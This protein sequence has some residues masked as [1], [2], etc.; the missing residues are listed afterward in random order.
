MRLAL[1]SLIAVS[2]GAPSAFAQT[3]PPA[4][5]AQAPPVQAPTP[6]APVSQAPATQAPAAA[7][8]PPAAA[9]SAPPPTPPPPPAPPT[10]PTAIAI[11]AVLQNVCIP[12]ASGGDLARLAKAAGYRKSGD[13]WVL[14]QRG[15]MLTIED[16]GSNPNQC[17]V[18]VIHAVDQAAPGR[19]IVLALEDWAAVERGW[20]LYRNDTNIQDGFQFT[21]RSWQ[22]AADGLQ[23]SI[24]FW[25]RRHPDGAP[26]RRDAD[27]SQLIYAETKTAS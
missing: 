4:P 23:Q 16:P 19:P 8:S 17:H 20:S 24:V 22:H 7:P 1:V 12:A 26:M 9:I 13:N 27:T 18:D 5:P 15:Y 11:L 25:T 3:A 21:T 6:Q 10:D 2:M 14:R